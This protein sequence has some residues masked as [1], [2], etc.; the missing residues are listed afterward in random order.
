LGSPFFF[1]PF[2]F[3]PFFFSPFFFSPLFF[4]PLFFS[5][6]FFSRLGFDPALMLPLEA[7]SAPPT[8]L[9]VSRAVSVLLDTLLGELPS[10]K[11]TATGGADRGRSSREGRFPAP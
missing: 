10:G 8:T 4:S 1:S 3:S 11:D 9:L 6:L 5:P 7:T 2:F